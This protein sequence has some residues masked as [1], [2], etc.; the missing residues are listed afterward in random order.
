[1]Y[2]IQ[3]RFMPQIVRLLKFVTLTINLVICIA[4]CYLFLL[5]HTFDEQ[6]D[7]AKPAMQQQ[8]A[9][10]VYRKQKNEDRATKNPFHEQTDELEQRGL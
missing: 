7:K 10:S 1:M 2:G 3:L 9:Q 6:M 8:T 5:V 4:Y